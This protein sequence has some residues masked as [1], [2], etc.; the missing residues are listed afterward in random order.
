MEGMYSL[1]S[2]IFFLEDEAATQNLAAAFAI[3]LSRYCTTEGLGPGMQWH[4]MG[5]L[6]AGKTT[7][8]RAFLGACGYVGRVN[9]PTYTL[10]EPYSVVINAQ[11]LVVYHFDLYRLIHEQEWEEAGFRDYFSQGAL[12]LVEWPQRVSLPR[13]DLNLRLVHQGLARELHIDAWTSAGQKLLML[14]Q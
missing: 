1:D 6:G 7:F 2:K 14:L 13:P 5:D 10:C 11:P 4:L 9:S 3:A 12:C 8:A